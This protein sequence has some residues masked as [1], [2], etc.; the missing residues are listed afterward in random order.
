MSSKH[1]HIH[2]C[3]ALV[4][5]YPRNPCLVTLERPTNHHHAISLNDALTHLH[6]MGVHVCGGVNP[7][8]LV[9]GKGQ[10]RIACRCKHAGKCGHTPE[11]LTN[12]LRCARLH[13]HVAWI[14]LFQY[15]VPLARLSMHDLALGDKAVLNSPLRELGYQRRGPVLLATDHLNYKNTHRSNTISVRLRPSP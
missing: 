2:P 11:G 8:D 14:Q 15:A 6:H 3:Q 9:G 1:V 5:V 7:G 4:P 10:T 12:L 13:K